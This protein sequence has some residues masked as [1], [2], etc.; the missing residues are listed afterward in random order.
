M[1]QPFNNPVN[2][3]QELGADM[4]YIPSEHIQDP[5]GI[6]GVEEL[7][8][9]VQ[10]HGQCEEE[11]HEDEI[12]AIEEVI[13]EEDDAD[14][15][16][17]E[18]ADSDTETVMESEPSAS[19][20]VSPPRYFIHA[21]EAISSPL[22]GRKLDFKVDAMTM[23][24][25][26]NFFGGASHEATPREE[27]SYSNTTHELLPSP[28][29]AQPLPQ[30]TP[31][32]LQPGQFVVDSSFLETL[33]ERNRQQTR[34]E[35]QQILDSRLSALNTSGSQAQ[36]QTMSRG[37]IAPHVDTDIITSQIISLVGDVP[38]EAARE[39]DFVSGI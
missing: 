32:P 39:P 15:E 28:T 5:M 6:L 9:H 8:T 27:M 4:D 19:P 37:N 10:T 12:R 33:L 30:P 35:M 20:Q 14:V 34:L 11:T 21:T 16:A 26:T 2:V 7:V 31:L 17:E 1:P 3:A 24:M 29:Q 23:N 13:A 38:L 18:D 36:E 22:R 25:P